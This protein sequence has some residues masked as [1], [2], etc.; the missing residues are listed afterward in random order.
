MKVKT[1]PVTPV[2]PVVPE[3]GT[4]VTPPEIKTTPVETPCEDL[5][6]RDTARVD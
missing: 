2:T 1:A 3:Q 5:P 6:L 4:V